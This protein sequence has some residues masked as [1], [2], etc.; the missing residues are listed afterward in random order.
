MNE[1]H[2]SQLSPDKAALLRRTVERH[3]PCLLPLVDALGA[4]PLNEADR[5][6][7]RSAVL[8]EFLRAGRDSDD[9]P[10]PDGLELEELIDAL[11]E[12]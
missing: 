10:T 7:L 4:S 8:A 3:E 9:A 11:G 1:S 2:R 6:A 5:E 12:Y